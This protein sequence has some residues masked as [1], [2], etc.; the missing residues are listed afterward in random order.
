MIRYLSYVGP[1]HEKRIDLSIGNAVFFPQG[2]IVDVEEK[3]MPERLRYDLLNTGLFKLHE[4]MADPLE[5]ECP[6]CGKVCKN[7]AGLKAHLRR[8]SA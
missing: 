3:G 4:S 6:K 7:K 2:Q 5:F 1:K 8:C